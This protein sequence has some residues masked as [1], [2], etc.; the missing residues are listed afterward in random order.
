MNPKGLRERTRN[1]PDPK[2]WARQIEVLGHG[3]ARVDSLQDSFAEECIT[4]ALR[5]EVGVSRSL[6]RSATGASLS[7]Y[8]DM[9]KVK[10]LQSQG[11]LEWLEHGS[12]LS[13]LPD[14][15]RNAFHGG[16]LRATEKGRV[17]LD[18]I[19]PMILKD[20]A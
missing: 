13:A 20:I 5:T 18:L 17:V 7:D 16:S 2:R 1:V 4:L 11:L 6:F 8:L 12:E 15:F 9:S 19:S 10:E 14:E 3:Q